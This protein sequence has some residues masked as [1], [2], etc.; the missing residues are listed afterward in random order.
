MTKKDFHL[1]GERSIP[2][3]VDSDERL[4][5]I[6][7]G[8]FIPEGARDFFEAFTMFHSDDSV[9]SILVYIDSFGGSI[10]SLAT[11]AELIESSRKPI[12]T[13]CIGK[14]F[15]AGALLLS[16]GHERWMGPNS[17]VML[18]KARVSMCGDEIDASEMKVMAE[19]V[20]KLNDMWLKKAVARS[21]MS[22]EDFNKKLDK[23]AGEWYLS[24][25]EARKYGFIDHIGCP[26]VREVRQWRIDS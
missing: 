24:P 4:P 13:A 1:L 19:E 8:D 2:I 12:I 20:N 26:I 25:K 17:R 16:L 5:V 9:H 14:A 6:W 21:K 10:D 15:S 18:H 7:V 11:V 22:Y 3:K 23:V